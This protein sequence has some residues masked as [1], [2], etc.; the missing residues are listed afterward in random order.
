MNPPLAL[1]TSVPWAGPVTS[2]AESALPSTSLSFAST[3]P[4]TT[5]SSGFVNESGV[6][7][8]ASFTAAMFNVTRVVALV[9]APSLT[10]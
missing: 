10:R 1:K 4:V 7:A 6:V 5:V 9:S 2:D 3:L 8:G